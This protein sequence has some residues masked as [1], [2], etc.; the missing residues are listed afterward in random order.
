MSLVCAEWDQDLSGEYDVISLLGYMRYSQ[1]DLL[2]PLQ[3]EARTN[4]CTQHFK[5]EEGKRIDDLCNTLVFAVS[6]GYPTTPLNPGG[7]YTIAQ[8]DELVNRADFDH[9]RYFSGEEVKKR[10]PETF[11]NFRRG[12]LSSHFIAEAFEKAGERLPNRRR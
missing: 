11:E 10:L 9:P 4:I 6:K 5:G 3:T 7:N 8:G 12:A 1:K 2:H